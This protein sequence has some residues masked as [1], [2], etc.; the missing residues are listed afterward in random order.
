MTKSSA[1]RKFKDMDEDTTLFE[2][3]IMNNEL[4]KPLYDLMDLTSKKGIPTDA[5]EMAQKYTRLLIEANIPTAAIA[6]EIVVTALMRSADSDYEYPNFRRDGNVDY[7]LVPLR[8]ALEKNSSINI[9]LI[10]Q[11]LKRQLLSPDLYVR[12]GE[13]VHDALFDEN[14]DTSS[15]REFYNKKDKK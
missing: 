12:K 10:Y 11:D 7:R 14:I 4:T 9:G 3:M 2:T 1:F 15:L 8:T 6:G 5:N 13:S